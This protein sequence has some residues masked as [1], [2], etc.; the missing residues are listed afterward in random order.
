MMSV[1][2][3]KG[4]WTMVGLFVL[5]LV[6]TLLDPFRLDPSGYE[7]HSAIRA[8]YVIIP[9]GLWYWFFVKPSFTT[10]NLSPYEKRVVLYEQ[11]FSVLRKILVILGSLMSLGL[12]KELPILKD[13][14]YVLDTLSANWGIAVEAI[15]TLVGIVL[16]FISHFSNP[17]R[18]AV[19]GLIEPKKYDIE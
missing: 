8:V 2:N 3:N 7:S 18:F 12:F 13:I 5:T 9:L 17:E 19:R 10:K 6:L 15:E 11:I 4:T 1:L 16:L 14:H